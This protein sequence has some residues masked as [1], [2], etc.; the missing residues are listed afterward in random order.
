M[1]GYPDGWKWAYNHEID[2]VMYIHGTGSSGAQG[3]I[4]RAR[5]NRQSTVIGHIHSFGGVSYSASDRDIIFGMNVG[6]GIDVRSYAMA[7]GKVY[8][9]KPTTSI[10]LLLM[11][12]FLVHTLAQM[13]L[14]QLKH[15][16]HVLT[17]FLDA[18]HVLLIL[19]AVYARKPTSK[20][21]LVME[22]LLVYKLVQM[23]KE[24]TQHQRHV[25]TA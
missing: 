20:I 5:D 8:A 7:Y 22:L 25:L 23:E 11:E 10:L 1:L 19:I 12:L 14:G 13:E 16:R 15:Q 9:K 21:Q 6:C 17:A 18:K 3:A 24:Q 4:N 2:N